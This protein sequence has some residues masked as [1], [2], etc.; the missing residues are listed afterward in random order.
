MA[1]GSALNPAGVW[2]LLSTIANWIAAPF[3]GLLGTAGSAPDRRYPPDVGVFGI[4]K[5]IPRIM[6]REWQ[7][8]AWY[9]PRAIV[10]LLLYFIPAL[11]RR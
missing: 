9:L 2:L 8:L 5:D 4:M 10:L 7:E 11:G 6:K 1:G 3:S